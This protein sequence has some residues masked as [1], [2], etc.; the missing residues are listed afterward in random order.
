MIKVNVK[1]LAEKMNRAWVPGD[2]GPHMSRLLIR[3]WQEIAKGKPVTPG[4]TSTIID[5]LGI[6]AAG[7][8]AFLQKMA[9]KDDDGNIVGILGLSQ[10]NNWAHKLTVNGI[11]LR[12]WCA[13]DQFFLAQVLDQ[14][15]L[16]ESKCP[17]SGK[18]I[19][20]IIA[21]DGVI[22][23]QPAGAAV[24]IVTLD[25]DKYDKRKLEELWSGL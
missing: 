21:P 12:S 20:I 10:D 23:C 25:P 24:S 5:K 2:Y 11:P 6:P 8:E 3:T 17:V 4:R 14:T 18:K 9:E 22:A 15:V 1:E 19:T 7:A 16:G 13:W